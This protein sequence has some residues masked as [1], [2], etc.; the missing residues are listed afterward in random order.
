MKERVITFGDENNLV[1][2]LTETDNG[3]SNSE[4]PCVLILNSGILH[5]VG[6]FR[7]HVVAARALAKAGFTVFRMDIGGIGDSSSS[8]VADYDADRVIS[9]I[10]LAMDTI[11]RQKAVSRFVL[12]GLCTGAANAHKVSVVD[13]RVTGGI[14][15]DGYVYAT[16]RF[17]FNRYLPAFLDPVRGK[18]WILRHVRRIA[19][20]KLPAAS[21]TESEATE[22]FGW[23]TLPPKHEVQTDLAKLVDRNVNLLYIFSGEQIDF[24]NYEKQFVDAFATVNFKDTLTVIYNGEADHTYSIALDRDRLVSQVVDWLKSC[25][26]P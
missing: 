26:G 17:Y 23:W 10:R 25:Y 13:E 21:E 22:D 18:N 4:P 11:S 24:Y 6:P 1:G 14:F 19:G 8:K 20:E 16:W 3:S 7:L 15:L 9:D 12:M 2:I 5:H